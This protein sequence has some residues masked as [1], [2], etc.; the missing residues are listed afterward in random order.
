MDA[1]KDKREQADTFCGGIENIQCFF[2]YVF[3]ENKNVAK[4]TS[5]MTNLTVAV[6]KEIRK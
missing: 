5:S 1:D 2:D 4:D 6:S 3:T